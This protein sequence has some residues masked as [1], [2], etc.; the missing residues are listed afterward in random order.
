MTKAMLVEAITKE[1]KVSNVEIVKVYGVTCGVGY[2]MLLH[3][4]F[5]TYKARAYRQSWD[6]TGHHRE[7]ERDFNTYK[8]SDNDP[9]RY[10]EAINKYYTEEDGF[11]H[12]LS[13]FSKIML[14][15]TYE[16]L[17]QQENK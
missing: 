17:K 9:L 6:L 14:Q 11:K 5:M 1:V 15:A 16:V 12:Y 3:T 8:G 7:N 10:E 13:R 4:N 2:D